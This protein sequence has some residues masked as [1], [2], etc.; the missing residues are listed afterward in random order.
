MN[1]PT[2]EELEAHF[3]RLAEVELSNRGLEYL[4]DT[5]LYRAFK[6]ATVQTALDMWNLLP[7][8]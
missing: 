4:K 2:R 3:D 7:N 1:S 8:S 5:E 6:E